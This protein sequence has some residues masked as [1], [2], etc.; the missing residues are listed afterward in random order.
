ML[1]RLT[2]LF[3]TLP[4]STLAQGYSGYTTVGGQTSTPLVSYA[5]NATLTCS[6]AYSSNPTDYPAGCAI[7]S[8]ILRLGNTVR[9]PSAGTGY[10]FCQGQAYL[11]CTLTVRNPGASPNPTPPP[12]ST[13]DPYEGSGWIGLG[14]PNEHRDA[15]DGQGMGIAFLNPVPATK[16]VVVTFSFHNLGG[17]FCSTTSGGHVLW[18]DGTPQENFPGTVLQH[19]DSCAK[20]GTV[21][22]SAASYQLSHNYTDVGTFTIFAHAQG[23]FKDNGDPGGAT[24]FGTNGS[25][26]S[27]RCI[28][29]KYQSVSVVAPPS[30][31]P[32]AKSVCRV[33]RRL[34]PCVKSTAGKKKQKPS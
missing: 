22:L 13:P 19:D 25:S 23:D 17:G 31:G 26:G 2:I 27:W 11:S 32:A 14:G 33:G 28:E 3:L 8:W 20:A 12:H 10:L 24:K 9:A 1:L 5:A 16:G 4:V 15:C 18:G 34:G 6:A 30:P 29:Q 21:R 7:T